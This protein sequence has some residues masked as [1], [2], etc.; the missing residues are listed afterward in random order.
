MSLAILAN[1]N[2]NYNFTQCYTEDLLWEGAGCSVNNNCCTNADQPW[3]FCQLVTNRQDDIEA[4]LCRAEA[5]ENEAILVEQIQL[6]VQQPA[7]AMTE[8]DIDN[9]YDL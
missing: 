5:F 3:F 7:L 6:Y 9:C 1:F 2:N 4:R 8:V